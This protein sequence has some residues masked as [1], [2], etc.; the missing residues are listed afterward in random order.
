VITVAGIGATFTTNV[1]GA[2]LTLHKIERRIVMIVV[3]VHQ[4]VVTD[5]SLIEVHAYS[6]GGVARAIGVTALAACSLGASGVTASAAGGFTS[7]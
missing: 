3:P 1:A 4:R 7:R 5:Q 6:P 2:P